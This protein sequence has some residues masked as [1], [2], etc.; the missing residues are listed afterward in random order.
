MA[1]TKESMDHVIVVE[2]E[3]LPLC[4]V[5]SVHADGTVSMTWDQ[6]RARRMGVA[7][8]A[9]HAGRLNSSFKLARFESRRLA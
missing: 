9:R 3:G 6:A 4:Y 2:R 8:A 7:A 1:R 5:A